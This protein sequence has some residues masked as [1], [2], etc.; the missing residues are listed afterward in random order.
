MTQINVIKIPCTPAIATA[1]N[2]DAGNAP[3]CSLF[4]GAN[5]LVLPVQPA[6]CRRT[7]TG[8]APSLRDGF[9]SSRVVMPSRR[10]Q[11]EYTIDD[12]REEIRWA[13]EAL[14]ANATAIAGTYTAIT[15]YDYV[16]LEAYQDKAQ[17]YTLRRGIMEI[18]SNGGSI[19]YLA[20]DPTSRRLGLGHTLKFTETSRRPYPAIP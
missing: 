13:C 5:N 17:G 3:Y 8:E 4:D 19:N 20:N 2:F 12:A 10:I 9:I 16:F 6:S 7:N 11:I 1:L 14:I 18:E 15:L